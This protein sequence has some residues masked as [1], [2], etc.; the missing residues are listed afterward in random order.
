MPRV[1]TASRQRRGRWLAD[2][3]LIARSPIFEAS[4]GVVASPSTTS[5]R[6][7]DPEPV[8]VGGGKGHGAD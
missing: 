8:E 3:E 6:A 2:S 5:I 7:P 1:R 4:I